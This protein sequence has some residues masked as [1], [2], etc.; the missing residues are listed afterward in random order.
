MSNINDK[1]NGKAGSIPAGD[2]EQY[3]VW[4]KAGPETV[5]DTPA[6]Q[7]DFDLSDLS[8][9]NDASTEI[10]EEE[11]DLLGSLEENS[12]QESGGVEPLGDLDDFSFDSLEETAKEPGAADDDDFSFP[13]IEDIQLGNSE[14]T[15]ITAGTDDDEAGD[16]DDFSL[17]EEEPLSEEPLEGESLDL[18]F[19]LDEPAEEDEEKEPFDDIAAV[20]RE[21]TESSPE[22]EA[23]PELE[24]IEPEAELELELDSGVEIEPE[25]ETE[26]ELDVDMETE[27]EPEIEI[28]ESEPEPEPEPVAPKSAPVAAEAASAGIFSKIEE[29]LASIKAELSNLKKELS[30][31]RVAGASTPESA[32]DSGFFSG[33][34]D[35]DETIALTGDELDNILSTADITEED[36]ESD[37]PDD[38]L[39]FNAD[40]PPSADEEITLEFPE[41]EVGAP[42][43]PAGDEPEIS[44]GDD[45][46]ISIEESEP[47]AAS[48]GEILNLDFDD[49]QSGEEIVIDM[50]DSAT[51]EKAASFEN[52]DDIISLD[53]GPSAAESIPLTTPEEQAIIEEYNRELDNF[54]AEDI[55]VEA[56]V[57]V[58][59]E[60]SETLSEAISDEA[61]LPG[62]DEEEIEFDLAS[63]QEAVGEEPETE[64]AGIEVEEEPAAAFE[65]DLSEI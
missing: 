20:E 2:L 32:A 47:E 15:G 33:D 54:G 62:E 63:L 26:T 37:V 36:G 6:D 16:D 46:P 39:N 19:N 11:E 43:A 34:E 24:E 50:T 55:H 64:A 13:D 48:P 10:T 52:S 22:P 41:T 14:A 35:E 28:T 42:A 23:E 5:K 8:E 45:E 1:E 51:E 29:E 40:A 38:I 60:A 12:R 30:G 18:D 61:A 4:V 9:E 58:E 44:F 21:M 57:E 56:P 53:D 59:E 7:D 3:G 31:L 49:T 25:A 27:P 65:D 17:P